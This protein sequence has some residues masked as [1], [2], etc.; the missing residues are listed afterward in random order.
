MADEGEE[1]QFLGN[2]VK[3]KTKYGST[4]KPLPK[5]KSYIKHTVLKGDTLMGIALKYGG[6]VRF[7]I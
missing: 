1:R 2:I 3:N 4:T 5:F 6:S 7:L